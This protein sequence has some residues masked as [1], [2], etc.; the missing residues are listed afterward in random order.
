[1][2]KVYELSGLGGSATILAHSKKPRPSSG[3]PSIGLHLPCTS[4]PLAVVL[5][6]YSSEPS[7]SV[8]YTNTLR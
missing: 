3:A 8:L 7:K 2:T 5:T 1:M 6:T 4:S